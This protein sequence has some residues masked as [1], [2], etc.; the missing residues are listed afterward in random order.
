MNLRAI[1]K[2]V[3]FLAGKWLEAKAALVDQEV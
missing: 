1:W 3:V 2:K